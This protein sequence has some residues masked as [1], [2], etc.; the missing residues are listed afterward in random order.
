MIWCLGWIPFRFSRRKLWIPVMQEKM[1]SRLQRH[2]QSVFQ[3]I[4]SELHLSCA[5]ILRR[6]LR[7]CP[8]WLEWDVEE[9]RH[10]ITDQGKTSVR[11]LRI[12]RESWIQQGCLHRSKCF[13]PC[14]KQFQE[15]GFH[16]LCGRKEECRS[17]P[18]WNLIAEFC[19]L[20]R[21][22]YQCCWACFE[23]Q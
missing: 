21:F 20:S 14:E 7:G 1:H 9:Y 6:A 16:E 19:V 3:K 4:Y 17:W 18:R 13:L 8:S 11:S 10:P 22:R 23:P 2:L 12:W 5:G 15:K